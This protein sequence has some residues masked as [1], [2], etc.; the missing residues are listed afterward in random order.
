[1]GRIEV[2]L[3]KIK[4]VSLVNYDDNFDFSVFLK[5]H[6]FD[7]EIDDVVHH[8]YEEVMTEIDCKSCANCCKQLDILL[9]KEDIQKLAQGLTM[10]I[11][12]FEQQYVV[13]N[14]LRKGEEFYDGYLFKN[15]PCIFLKDKLCGCYSFRPEICEAYPSLHKKDI[16]CRLSMVAADSV[17]CPIMFNVLEGLKE[18][19]WEEYLNDDVG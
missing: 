12:E 10:S 7:K 13:K 18:R 8:L 16:S 2:D 6:C 4:Q 5:R 17:I 11:E 1:M 19:Y 3:K 9:S 14:Y 15:K